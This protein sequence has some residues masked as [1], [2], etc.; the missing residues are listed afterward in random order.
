MDEEK[1]FGLELRK[2]YLE[3]IRRGDRFFVRYDAGAQQ[4]AWREDEISEQEA[5][6][7]GSGRAGEYDVIVCLQRR[8]RLDAN[9]SNWL[10]PT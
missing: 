4:M 3:V 7:I 6:S 2:D 5:M 9:T 1:L 10:P 8:L